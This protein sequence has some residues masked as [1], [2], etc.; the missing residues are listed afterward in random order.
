MN[1]QSGTNSVFQPYMAHIIKRHPETWKGSDCNT[2]YNSSF[3]K[4]MWSRSRFS[5]TDLVI[6]ISSVYTALLHVLRDIYM[7]RTKYRKQNS[8][9]QI[10]NTKQCRALERQ[11]ESGTVGVTGKV[12]FKFLLKQGVGAWH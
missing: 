8:Q 9:R 12:G 1:F 11:Q 7:T 10:E 4:Q 6:I 5:P 3:F 2:P